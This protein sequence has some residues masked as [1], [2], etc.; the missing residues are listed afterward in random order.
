MKRFVS[1]DSQYLK[2]IS[3]RGLVIGSELTV[4][5]KLEFDDSLLA[6]SWN[7]K[8]MEQVY[9][10]GTVRIPTTEQNIATM[11]ELTKEQRSEIR[12]LTSPMLKE[13]DYTGL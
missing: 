9:P 4:C 6:P 3:D 11:N 13:F 5:E 7:G 2:Y 12:T 8:K 10:W 1:F